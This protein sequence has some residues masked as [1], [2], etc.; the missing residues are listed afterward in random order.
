MLAKCSVFIA[1]SLD[2]FIA[3]DDGSIDWLMKANTLVPPG[4]DGG[5]KEFIS[6]VN[7]LVMGR[8]SFEKV[9]SFESWPYGDLPVVVMS[10]QSIEIPSHLKN[11]VSM[12]SETPVDLVKRLTNQGFKHLYIDGGI[13]IQNFIVDNLIDELTITIA[14]VLLGSGRSLF[15]PLTH[16]IELDHIETK[17]IG[18]GFT[19]LKYRIHSIADTE[20][21]KEKNKNKVSLVYDEMIDWF[22]SHRNKELDMEQFY[23]DFL[24]NHIPS[25]GKVLDVGC[26]TGEPI[27]QFLIKKG[28]KVTGID[29][30]KKM[31]HLC[32]KRFPNGKWLLADMRTLNLQD[33]FH[34][35]IAWHSLFHLPHDDQRMVLK[36]L[37]SLVEQNGL[38]IFTSGSEYGE[39]WGDNGG[40]DLYHA[41]LSAEEYTQILLNCNFKVL[42]HNVS[43]PKCGEATVWVTQKKE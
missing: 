36:S 20:A 11:N 7:G 12:S 41:S 35:V 8:H 30:S 23:L 42:I 3:R 1:T 2:G 37:S 22:D 10:S 13:T 28:Y 14:P 24:Q 32:K 4:E 26:G 15:G 39:V 16:D 34:A 18:G 5:Y 33:K 29:A 43:D 19:Q 31:I 25:G 40:Y 6:T 27:A 21:V 17:C 38:L 9:L